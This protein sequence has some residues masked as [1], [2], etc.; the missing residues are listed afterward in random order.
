MIATLGAAAWPALKP[1]YERLMLSQIVRIRRSFAY[2]LCE[3]AR[4]IGP[5]ATMSELTPKM[6]ILLKDVEEVRMGILAGLTDFLA[7]LPPKHREAT[8]RKLRHE[9][10]F[11]DK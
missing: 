1:I 6:F 10:T 5:D 9:L 7:V 4:I 3:V 2:S 8:A 11:M